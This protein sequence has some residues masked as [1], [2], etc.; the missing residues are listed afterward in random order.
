[1]ITKILVVND[2]PEECHLFRQI[3]SETDPAIE[4]YYAFNRRDALNKMETKETKKPDL[5]IVDINPPGTNGWE[6]L[7]AVNKDPAYK[8]IPAIVCSIALDKDD[9][10]KSLMYGCWYFLKPEKIEEL[11]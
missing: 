9:I 2:D 6:F 4:C 7:G 10:E 1:M 11:K 8:N 5:Y 3:I